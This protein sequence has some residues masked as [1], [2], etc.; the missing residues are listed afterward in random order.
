MQSR[1][2][3]LARL[4]TTCRKGEKRVV[5]VPR[6]FFLYVLF[7]NYKVLETKSKLFEDSLS[8]LVCRHLS[9]GDPRTEM[10]DNKKLI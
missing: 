3:S 4:Q 1:T 7:V 6:Y 9:K 10:S 8:N 5:S 2:P